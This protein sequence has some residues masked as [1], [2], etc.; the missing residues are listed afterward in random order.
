VLFVFV[1]RRIFY[2]VVDP[3]FVTLSGI[4]LL[5]MDVVPRLNAMRLCLLAAVDH[6]LQT[7]AVRI[8]ARAGINLSF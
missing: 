3:T 2:L 6:V 5:L 4:P 7:S 8:S 1:F